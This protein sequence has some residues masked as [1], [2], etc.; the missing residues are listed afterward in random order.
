MT[1]IMMVALPDMSVEVANELFNA[2]L[3]MFE[4]SPLKFS[5]NNRV[6]SLAKRKIENLIDKMIGAVAIAWN[7]P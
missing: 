3:E 2:L 1:L 4:C 5:H 7:E 6:L